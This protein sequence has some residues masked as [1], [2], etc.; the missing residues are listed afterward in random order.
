MLSHAGSEECFNKTEGLLGNNNGDPADDLQPFN[1]SEF[2]PS[3]AAVEDTEEGDFGKLE[4]SNM[5]STPHIN[6]KLSKTVAEHSPKDIYQMHVLS[7][8][9]ENLEL[10]LFPVDHFH[11]CNR[12]FS[13]LLSSDLDS[14]PALCDETELKGNLGVWRIEFGEFGRREWVNGGCRRQVM[15]T[16]PCCFDYAAVGEELAL[17]SLADGQAVVET[18]S[19][20]GFLR[21]WSLEL[22]VL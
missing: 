14:C 18:Q 10:S 9:I 4:R 22:V 5:L 21:V 2:L 16:S 6:P 15:G 17:A 8:C 12:L 13:P 11:S 19:Q 1:S 3:D 7:W 20:A